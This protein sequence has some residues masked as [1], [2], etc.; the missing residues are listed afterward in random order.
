MSLEMQRLYA[1]M[2]PL[3]DSFSIS[4]FPFLL[5]QHSTGLYSLIENNIDYL[6]PSHEVWDLVFLTIKSS[7]EASLS[8]TMAYKMVQLI[9]D[10]KALRNIV[11]VPGVYNAVTSFIAATTSNESRYA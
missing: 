2:L 7:L 4:H 1:V 10:D 3:T 8:A 6:S 5:R 9:V 11:P